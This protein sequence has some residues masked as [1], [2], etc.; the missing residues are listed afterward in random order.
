MQPVN[1]VET[2]SWI[3]ERIAEKLLEIETSINTWQRDGRIRTS[4]VGEEAWAAGKAFLSIIVNAQALNSILCNLVSQ[5][6]S[7]CKQIMTSYMDMSRHERLDVINARN[8][9]DCPAVE[10]QLRA[11]L[12]LITA[13][14]QK[15][16]ELLRDHLWPLLKTG[17]LEAQT[18]AA[19]QHHTGFHLAHLEDGFLMLEAVLIHGFDRERKHFIEWGNRIEQLVSKVTS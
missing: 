8:E 12:N 18:R 5:N 11:L 7:Q 4:I 10:S 2:L 6:P 1:T 19:L 9:G 13:T 3:L 16:Y 15:V 14:R 17:S